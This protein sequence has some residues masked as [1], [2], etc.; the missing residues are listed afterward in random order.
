MINIKYSDKPTNDPAP[1]F[2]QGNS[3]ATK[4]IVV[5]SLLGLAW[6]ASLRAWSLARQAQAQSYATPGINTNAPV[7][8]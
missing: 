6:G 7:V 3:T 8:N 2:N 4:H 5:G 1:S